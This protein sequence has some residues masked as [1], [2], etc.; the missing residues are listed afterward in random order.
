MTDRDFTQP[1]EHERRVA[2]EVEGVDER[3]GD[4][5]TPSYAAEIEAERRGMT[6]HEVEEEIAED[7]G[8]VDAAYTPRT[9]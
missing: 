1:T 2:E 9:G 3:P 4:A 5:G 7:E 6:G 8:G